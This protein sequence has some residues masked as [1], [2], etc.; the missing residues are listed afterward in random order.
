VTRDEFKRI[1][2][3]ACYEWKQKLDNLMAEQPFNDMLEFTGQQVKTML[4]ASTKCQEPIVRAVFH[5][6]DD[7]KDAEINLASMEFDKVFA[8]IGNKA[9]IAINIED[10]KSFYLN[11]GYTWE[12]RPYRDG[13]Q[14]LIPTKK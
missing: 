9:M 12:L 7:G 13:N 4:D 1:Y 8:S 6:Y 11:K 5:E 10:D 3:V 14:I 2:D